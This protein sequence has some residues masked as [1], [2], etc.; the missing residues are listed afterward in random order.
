MDD[1][2][3]KTIQEEMPVAGGGFSPTVLVFVETSREF[4]RSLVH[5]IAKYSRL[6]GHWRVYQRPVALDSSLP[7]WRDMKIDGAI[8]RDVRVAQSLV[9]FGFSGCLCPA[10]PRHL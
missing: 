2:A 8:A 7:D 1:H 6:H 3:S 5:G 4:G 9:R 10:Q